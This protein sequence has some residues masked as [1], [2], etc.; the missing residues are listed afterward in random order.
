[1][2]TPTITT[3]S[4]NGIGTPSRATVSITGGAGRNSQ[5]YPNLKLNMY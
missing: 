3:W 4:S 5:I 1:M 2:I